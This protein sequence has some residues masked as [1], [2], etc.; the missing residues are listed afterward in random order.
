MGFKDMTLHLVLEILVLLIVPYIFW[1][2][3]HIKQSIIHKRI[4]FFIALG[5]LIIDVYAVLNWFIKPWLP[6]QAFHQFT[7]GLALPAGIYMV[8]LGLKQ[9]KW[10]AKWFLIIF[11]ILGFFIDGYLLFFTW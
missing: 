5:N 11:G 4:L 9:E 6:K 2:S 7:E 3:F 8:W 1:L 10:L